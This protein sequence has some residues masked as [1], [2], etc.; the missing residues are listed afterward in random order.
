[1]AH[2][3]SYRNM[4]PMACQ[5]AWEALTGLAHPFPEVFARSRRHLKSQETLL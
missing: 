3:I 5:S 1:M 2:T 4:A